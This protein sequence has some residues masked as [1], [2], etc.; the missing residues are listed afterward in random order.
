MYHTVLGVNFA[1]Y[2]IVLE[3]LFYLF[4]LIVECSVKQWWLSDC[5]MWLYLQKLVLSPMTGSLIFCRKHRHINTL[6]SFTAKMKKS[7]VVCFCWLLFPSPLTIHTS[8]LG[9]SWEGR[10][11]SV[12][13]KLNKDLCC[14]LAIILAGYEP[15]VAHIDTFSYS[16]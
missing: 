16:W 14:L 1:F 6:S 5:Y 12:T 15:C 3:F 11:L 4:F 9:A 13:V 10:G 8:S 7:W 2:C